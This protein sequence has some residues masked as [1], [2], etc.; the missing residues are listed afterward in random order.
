MT[1][2]RCALAALLF[3]AAGA[4]SANPPPSAVTRWQVD[5]GDQYCSLIRVPDSETRFVVA[6]R[7]LP[8]GDYSDLY[9][10]PR[11]FATAPER[12]DSVQLLPS[13]R[14]FD[15]T[16][17]HDYAV[18]GA[19]RLSRLP[20]DFVDAF[21][22]A[23]AIVLKRHGDT[24]AQVPLVNSAAA[25]G[26]LRQCISDAMHQWGVDEAAWRALSRH[27]RALDAGISDMDY[28]IQAIRQN[29][30]GRVVMR[31]EVS[32]QGRATACVP[33]ATSHTP[34]ID[35]AACN[36]VMTRGRFEP[37]LNAAG[38]PIAAQFITTVSFFMPG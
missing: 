2:L 24:A 10:V 1:L 35:A 12:I 30:Q 19:Y 17:G 3:A 6:L 36:A 21:A 20:V 14:A 7:V 8:G 25:A 23:Q 26:A 37:A 18:P 27:P 9:L 22:G 32:A 11:G 31:V 28:P 13:A 4:A 16:E 33:V 15:V 29:Q 34:T 38:Q 5:W